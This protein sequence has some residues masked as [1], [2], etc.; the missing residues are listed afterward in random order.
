MKE[1]FQAV[2][3]ELWRWPTPTFT[4]PSSSGSGTRRLGSSSDRKPATPRCRSSNTKLKSVDSSRSWPPRSQCIT[5]QTVWAPIWSSSSWP[6]WA[7]K[8]EWKKKLTKNSVQEKCQK[9]FSCKKI[10]KISLW[11]D[12]FVNITCFCIREIIGWTKSRSLN[13][14]CLL[15]LLSMKLD[16]FVVV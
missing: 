10:L 13:P 9:L 15:W 16:N 4:R 8:V 11:A 2:E 3:L 6:G 12:F 14:L 7:K 5:L 1:T